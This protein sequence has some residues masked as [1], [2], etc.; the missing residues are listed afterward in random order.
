MSDPRFAIEFSPH[1]FNEALLRSYK[2][3]IQPKKRRE[4]L[5]PPLPGWNPTGTV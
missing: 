3:R 5:L 1:S 4:R 2:D